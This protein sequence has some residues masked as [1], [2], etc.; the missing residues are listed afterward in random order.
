MTGAIGSSDRIEGVLKKKKKTS[1]H[2]ASRER[3]GGGGGKWT[4]LKRCPEMTRLGMG[5]WA[6][7]TR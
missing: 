6:L 2:E 1:T 3:T 5:R 7:G 4:E